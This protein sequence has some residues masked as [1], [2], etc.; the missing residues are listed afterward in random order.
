MRDTKAKYIRNSK[1]KTSGNLTDM[2][3]TCSSHIGMADPGASWLSS[4]VPQ[5]GH[6]AA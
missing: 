2:S 4:K 5:H 6:A 3:Y 1:S